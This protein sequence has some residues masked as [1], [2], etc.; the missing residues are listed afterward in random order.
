MT[1]RNSIGKKLAKDL[2]EEAKKDLLEMDLHEELRLENVDDYDTVGRNVGAGMW[3]SRN[4]Q[5]R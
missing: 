1:K 3:R 4:S 5:G 2:N